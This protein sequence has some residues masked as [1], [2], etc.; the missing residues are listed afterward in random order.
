MI[1]A[2]EIDERYLV[3][4]S[5]TSDGTQ[6][7][8][9]MDNKWYKVDRYGGEG[10]AEELASILLE[11]SNLPEKSYV[12]YNRV[13]INNSEGC[14]SD[15]FLKKGESYI[16]LYRL[17]SNIYGKDMAMVTSRMDYDDAIDYAHGQL[18]TGLSI[19]HI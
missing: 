2:I 17:Y 8:Y 7:K 3:R 19:R 10:I 18:S 11:N 5:G 6:E 16:T 12:K 14:V 9:F 13:L 1:S 4:D 15:N